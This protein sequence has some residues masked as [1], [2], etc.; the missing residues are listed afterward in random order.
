MADRSQ[1]PRRI[2][3]ECWL[4]GVFS[5]RFGAPKSRKLIK[6]TLINLHYP[7]DSSDC[8]SYL[9]GILQVSP[10]SLMVVSKQIPQLP[11][12]SRIDHEIQDT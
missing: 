10:G 1:G 12:L 3:S 8:S 6:D 2:G 7:N 11:W 5:I 4:K 9:P